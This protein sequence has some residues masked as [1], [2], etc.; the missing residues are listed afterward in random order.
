M[1]VTAEAVDPAQLTQDRVRAIIARHLSG[2]PLRPDYVAE[3]LLPIVAEV[4]CVRVS[5]RDNGNK[6]T[7]RFWRQP[8]LEV[9]LPRAKAVLRNMCA[10]VAYRSDP[11]T[12]GP[13][14]GG[15]GRVPGP[16]GLGSGFTLTMMNTMDG[17][18]CDL[19]WQGKRS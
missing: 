3:E 16:P 9:E 19:A 6:F 17:Y 1:A 2:R 4:G 15:V 18:W 7:F 12:G 11:G 13:T 10:N 5:H 14:F 8:E